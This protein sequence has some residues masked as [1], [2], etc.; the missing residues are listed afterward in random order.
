MLAA[1][2]EGGGEGGGSADRAICH[3]HQKNRKSL[4][5]NLQYMYSTIHAVYTNKPASVSRSTISYTL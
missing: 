1:G 2:G 3:Q 4:L 5:E